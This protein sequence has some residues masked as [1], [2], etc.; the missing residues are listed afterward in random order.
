M[1]YYPSILKCYAI[2]FSLLP[3]TIV[4]TVPIVFHCEI[5]SSSNCLCH[6]CKESAV[7][8]IITEPYPEIHN[9]KTVLVCDPPTSSLVT[10]STALFTSSKC[11]TSISNCMKMYMKCTVDTVY[12]DLKYY[13]FR[14]SIL[15]SHG[16]SG[17][18]WW[19]GVPNCRYQFWALQRVEFYLIAY[20]ETKYSEKS[21]VAKAFNF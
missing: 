9:Y 14:H 10:L 1:L 13:D 2:H 17:W 15:R 21:D 7:G 8:R 4:F 19:N 20:L 5:L 12:N 16:I 11:I 6:K 18:K 3:S